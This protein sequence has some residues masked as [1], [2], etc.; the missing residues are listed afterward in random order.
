MATCPNPKCGASTRV[1]P[2]IMEI[3]EEIV[4]K[5]L[6]TFSIAG[7]QMKV[8][9]YTQLRLV[10]RACDWSTPGWIEGGH[11]VAYPAPLEA[12]EHQEDARADDA[13]PGEP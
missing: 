3:V 9:A 6:G 12:Q 11:F 10:C 5:P 4:A 1:T 2:G 7:N 13:E 8:S